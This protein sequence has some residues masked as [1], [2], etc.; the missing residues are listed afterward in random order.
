MMHVAALAAAVA[1]GAGIASFV[2]AG[3]L[4]PL[5][6]RAAILDRPNERSSHSVPTPRGG[7]IAV[8]AAILA[9]WLALIGAGAAPP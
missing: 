8:V 4:I 6:R 2:G 9:A 5:L 7:G 1:I 3:A